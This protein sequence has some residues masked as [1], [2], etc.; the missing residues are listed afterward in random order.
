M[1]IYTDTLDAV[2]PKGGH[3]VLGS[4]VKEIYQDRINLFEQILKNEKNN[5]SKTKDGRESAEIK[6]HISELEFLIK[7]E[8]ADFSDGQEDYLM[9]LVQE[10]YNRFDYRGALAGLKKTEL[11]AKLTE[12]RTKKNSKGLIHR[13]FASSKKNVTKLTEPELLQQIDLQDKIS[14]L[15]FE[16][17]R[18]EFCDLSTDDKKYYSYLSAK[19]ILEKLKSISLEDVRYRDMENL[20]SFGILDELLKQNNVQKFNKLYLADAE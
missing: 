13:I 10:E 9:S 18:R 5:L 8:N 19:A 11:Q 14:N 4:Q 16:T 7:E 20:R 2:A 15:Y 17:L 6:K 12:L 3:V 1:G